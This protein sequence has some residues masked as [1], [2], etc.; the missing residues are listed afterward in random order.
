MKKSW[1]ITCLCL[2]FFRAISLGQIIHGQDTLYGHEWINYG[3]EYFK[4]TI[5]QDGIYRINYS[6]LVSA[7]FPVARIR[8][9]EVQLFYLGREQPVFTSTAELF[10]EGDYLEF[11]GQTN[12]SQVDRYLF[13]QADSAMLNPEYSLITDSSVYFLTY[14]S[15]PHV[16]YR[17][18][19][20]NQHPGDTLDWYWHEEKM[21]FS[22]S[23]FKPTINDDGV[24]LSEYVAGEGF[25]TTPFQNR[26]ITLAASNIVSNSFSPKLS[27]RLSGRNQEHEFTLT[28]NQSTPWSFNTS[29][30]M[31]VQELL[32]P[33]VFDENKFQFNTAVTN[34]RLVLG[35]LVLSYPRQAIFSK[36]KNVSLTFPEFY[37][38]GLLVISAPAGGTLLVYDPDTHYRQ[39]LAKQ[40]GKF[41]V[42][43]KDVQ[44]KLILSQEVSPVHQLEKVKFNKIDHTGADYVFITSKKFQTE[45]LLYSQYRQSEPGGNF[46]TDVIYVEDLY[47]Q[48]GYGL[49][50]HPLSIKNWANYAAAQYPQINYALLI[51]KGYQYPDVRKT[52]QK[53]F[54]P[55]YGLPGSQQML[56]SSGTSTIPHFAHGLLSATSG[57]E[58]LNYLA[59]IKDMEHLLRHAPQTIEDRAWMKRVLHMAAGNNPAETELLMSYL[60]DMGDILSNNKFG[61]IITP[62]AKQ[63]NS[64]IVDRGLNEQIFDL[65]NSGVA[66][67]T[68]FG[69]G[70]SSI[71]LLDSYEHPGIFNNYQKYPVMLSLG[72]FT[73]NAFLPGQSL[74]EE[75]IIYPEKGAVAYLATSGQGY[76]STLSGFGMD[77]YSSVG[78]DFFTGSLGV[79][80]KNYLAKHE[81][82]NFIPIKIFQQQLIYQGDP[83]YRLNYTRAP[84]FIINPTTIK[85]S[86]YENSN[87][88][89]LRFE[90]NNLGA[91]IQDS[92]QI[93]IKHTYPR[94]NVVQE[95]RINV[96][97][98]AE[99]GLISVVL[100]TR[101]E[102]GQH[103]FDLVINPASDFPEGPLPA[104]LDNN[105]FAGFSYFVLDDQAIP[106]FPSEFA[107]VNS[108]PVSLTATTINAFV[109]AQEYEFEIDTTTQF[110]KPLLKYR[111]DTV[112]SPV[113]WSI[114]VLPWTDQVYYWRVKPVKA[115]D[116]YWQVSSF[117]YA[118]TLPTGWNQSHYNQ[119]ERNS[120][121][122]L[123]LHQGKL[124]FEPQTTHIL[125]KNKISLNDRSAFDING[126]PWFESQDYTNTPCFVVT[127]FDNKGRIFKNQ[128]G[129]Y[130]NN[131]DRPITSFYFKT[132]TFEQRKEFI[133]FIEDLPTGYTIVLFP[134][135]D[136]KDDYKALDWAIDSVILGENIFTVLEKQGAQKIRS[137]VE[138]NRLRSYILLFI[139]DQYILQELAGQTIEETIISEF[140]IDVQGTNGRI[141]TPK[142]GPTDHWARAEIK[143][144]RLDSFLKKKLTIFLYD[145][146]NNKAIYKHY[147]E[148]II[149]LDSINAQEFPYVSLE[150]SLKDSSNFEPNLEF[151]RVYHGNQNDLTLGINEDNL[152][153]NEFL[154]GDT[155]NLDF[156]IHNLGGEWT[157]SIKIEYTIRDLFNK[158]AV[159]T[160]ILE[161]IGTKRTLNN[162]FSF[163]T[164]QFNGDCI[165]TLQLNPRKE[166]IETN[167]ENNFGQIG[168]RI[169][170]DILTPVLD[171]LFDQRRIKNLDEINSKPEIEFTLIDFKTKTELNEAN[172]NISIINPDNKTNQIDL[173]N[174]KI[175]FN[176]YIYGKEGQK[177]I[178]KWFPHFTLEG[179]YTLIVEAVDN[180]G[181]LAN[182]GPQEYKFSIKFLN[183]IFIQ[184]TPN[185]FRDYVRVEMFGASEDIKIEM[186]ELISSGGTVLK[187][188][189][190]QELNNNMQMSRSY[191]IYNVENEE[192]DLTAGTYYIK[193]NYKT[194]TKRNTITSV[195]IKN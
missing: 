91:F 138:G 164:E 3:Q 55:V 89:N 65:I 181:N 100:D 43:L 26:T 173:A 20:V 194:K 52:N 124:R 152:P 179:E 188:I 57:Q 168:V 69:H 15:G 187:T 118:P 104:A 68:Y 116:D 123:I 39:A 18:A 161:P 72:C 121:E 93:L 129:Q 53:G 35:T 150:L 172:F 66:I 147:D 127:V 101:G 106:A 67:K 177:A 85:V 42:D 79:I 140:N 9:D 109:D 54:L 73:G 185:P 92:V 111:T 113:Q 158:Q 166:F 167:Y 6:A 105:T 102:R 98:P 2:I 183:N 22:E 134:F 30:Q 46:R 7:G 5:S 10:K 34:D 74:S 82:I 61:A 38:R 36:L 40:N 117:L 157:D 8:A 180:E 32:L 70:N 135:R 160:Q 182:Q 99:K 37:P 103:L 145:K 13:Q 50:F 80:L 141:L 126:T 29:S 186:I 64:E 143:F 62:Y 17:P 24:R 41:Y 76:I 169:N 110:L 11:Y 153:I 27:F 146:K 162:T 151:I 163:N 144:S 14:S 95:T 128:P 31:L 59:K 28:H 60:N 195:L 191:I 193:V 159:F 33:R 115:G 154:Q 122:D 178:L 56:L 130:L 189:K 136:G 176:T 75:N 175:I 58:I 94:N 1:L 190:N 51:G 86:A 48:F 25:G 142:L 120:F 47:D 112:Y 165:V 156:S 19:V 78:Q 97:A 114:S 96:Q 12:R 4:L 132:Q 119:W 81:E 139:K 71:T 63:A 23:H 83:A 170:R 77:F 21:I 131:Y 155:M 148:G 45:V 192:V 133:N 90:I 171:V 149:S 49:P 16:R 108:L 184:V 107:I 87:T 84:D 137:I 88:I 174:E 44:T 125:I